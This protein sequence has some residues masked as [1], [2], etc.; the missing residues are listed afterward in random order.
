MAWRVPQI[1]RSPCPW[2]W[3]ARGGR[4][5]SCAMPHA[6]LRVMAQGASCVQ[7]H[8]CER[9][10]ETG[11]RGAR[12][13]RSVGTPYRYRIATNYNTAAVVSSGRPGKW[14]RH[15]DSTPY[16]GVRSCYR[17]RYLTHVSRPATRDRGLVRARVFEFSELSESSLIRINSRLR[18]LR[19]CWTSSASR[20]E[21][22]AAA[23][24]G[25]PIAFV[26]LICMCLWF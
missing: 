16:P 2:A 17:P 8:R 26:C 23:P 10:G 15:R 14:S 24:L 19:S 1:E 7:V 3:S 4:P 9:Q 11:G 6:W 20:T 21:S 12:Q 13:E 25:G 22:V 18:S 5:S